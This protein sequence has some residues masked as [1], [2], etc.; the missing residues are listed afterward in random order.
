MARIYYREEKLSG[1]AFEDNF[2]NTELF[3]FIFENS[4][5]NKFQLQDK[6]SRS[7]FG[8]VKS[9]RKVFNNVQLLN[10]GIHY[11]AREGNFFLPSAIIFFDLDDY[12]F[13]SEYYFIA[14][15]G[16]EIELLKY[17][18]GKDI[19]W[20]QTPELY[21]AVNDKGIISKIINSL[22]EIKSLVETV[23]NKKLEDERKKIEREEKQ[24]IEA[25]RPLLNDIQKKAF[26][27]LTELCAHNSPNKNNILTFIET[28]KDYDDD[29]ALYCFIAFLESNNFGFIMRMDWKAEVETLEWML[30]SV[31]EENYHLKI[32]LPNPQNYDERSTVSE[33]G[34][35]EDYGKALR[36]DNLQLGFIDTQSDEYIAIVH[37]I[38]DLESVKKAINIIGA[39]YYEK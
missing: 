16:N 7:F 8:L 36:E 32:T 24:K 33:K 37:K 25:N 14:N 34:I 38:Q 31:I 6:K 23:N 12:V 9:K 21:T 30:N 13:P 19:K 4:N 28:L 29:R 2:I 3:N 11:K 35:F 1:Q 22:V 5:T 10:D 18:A 15:V 17:N 26:Q 39:D 27:E 20:F